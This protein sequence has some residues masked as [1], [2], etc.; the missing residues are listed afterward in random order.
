MAW[1]PIA[2]VGVRVSPIMRTPRQQKVSEQRL[3][4]RAVQPFKNPCGVFLDGHDGVEHDS[5]REVLGHLFHPLLL[6][7]PG[8]FQAV[9]IEDAVQAA[10]QSRTSGPQ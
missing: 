6:E 9:G 10:Q 4:A 2:G 3:G 7:L 8:E 1:S 5:R